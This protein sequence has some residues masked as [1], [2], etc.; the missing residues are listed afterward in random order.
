MHLLKCFFVYMDERVDMQMIFKNLRLLQVTI[1]RNYYSKF[2]A[3]Q[4]AII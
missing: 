4:P 2:I 3:F 1:S